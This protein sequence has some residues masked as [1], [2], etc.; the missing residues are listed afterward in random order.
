MFSLFYCSSRE[1]GLSLEK[2]TTNYELAE[3]LAKVIPLFN[4]DENRVLATTKSFE[5]TVGDVIE[6][7]RS[8]FGKQADNL[9]QQS[10]DRLKKLI[11]ELAETVAMN[12]VLMIEADKMGIMVTEV[13]ID[14]MVAKQQ[15]S[16]GGEENFQNFLLSNGVTSQML[17]RDLKEYEIRRKY[18]DAL[19]QQ[20]IEISPSELEAALAEDKTATVR[21]ILLLTQGKSDEEKKQR[22][23]EMEELLKRAKAGEDFAELAKQFSEDPGSKDKGG[24]YEKFPRG[25]MVPSFDQAAFT[26]PVGEISDIVETSYGYHI[27]Q[28]VERQKDTRPAE[29]IEKELKAK[30]GQTLIKDEYDRLKN[31]YELVIAEIS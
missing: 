21:H 11:D 29:T 17:R 1:P 9:D 3:K 13:E 20:T 7:F 2:G 12:K 10:V 22:Y 23:T 18:L 5:V 19:R 4:P 30:K 26:V 25:Q 14:S 6:K 15:E 8:N 31:E 27:L 24:I 28:I 16:A